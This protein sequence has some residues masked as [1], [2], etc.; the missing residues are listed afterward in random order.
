M[1]GVVFRF[2]DNARFFFFFFFFFFF[3]NCCEKPADGTV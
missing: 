3:G 2:M 1:I